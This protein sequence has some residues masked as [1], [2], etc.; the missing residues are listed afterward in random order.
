MNFKIINPTKK[1]P[2]Y[3]PGNAATS[4]NTQKFGDS[5][6]SG[7]VLTCDGNFM[8]SY[9]FKIKLGQSELGIVRH[10]LDDAAR[11]GGM[12]KLIE[13]RKVLNL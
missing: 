8:S 6:T 4:N 1:D 9:G 3:Y 10:M 13:I 5:I 7:S 2:Y 12:Q 11:E